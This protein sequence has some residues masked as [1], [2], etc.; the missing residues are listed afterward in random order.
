M[1]KIFLFILILFSIFLIA[2][3]SGNNTGYAIV[4]N[5]QPEVNSNSAE[6]TSAAKTFKIS[7][8]NFK[9][10][11]DGKENPDLTVNQGDNVRIEFTSGQ[12]FHDFVIDELN[13]RTERVNDDSSTSVE[14]IADKKGTFEYYCSVGTHRQIGMKGKF[15][16]Q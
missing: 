1:K 16:I 9:F 3:S 6:G 5:S 2:C 11:M 14:F 4:D 15:I 7:G 10:F 13:A 8:E 12:G